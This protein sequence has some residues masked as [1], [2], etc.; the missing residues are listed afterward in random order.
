MWKGT[1]GRIPPFCRIPNGAGS[2]T[3]GIPVERQIGQ[4]P[5][6]GEDP[7]RL[8]EAEI[9][10]V[11][12]PGDRQPG[13]PLTRP[14]DEK[15]IALGVAPMRSLRPGGLEADQVRGGETAAWSL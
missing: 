5:S 1:S 15:T 3:S 4:Q 12:M 14:A 2:L 6:S 13:N 8:I 10:A 11:A 9:G 7:A